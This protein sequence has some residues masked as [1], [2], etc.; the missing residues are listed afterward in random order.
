MSSKIHISWTDESTDETSFKIFRSPFAN[1]AN[2][3]EISS[4]VFDGSWTASNA[5]LLTQN[6]TPSS[7]GE[8]FKI[9]FN[10]VHGGTFYYGV[11]SLNADGSSSRIASNS[12]NL[13]GIPL[14]IENVVSSIIADVTESV[15]AS[16]ESVSVIIVDDQPSTTLPPITTPVPMPV[17]PSSVSIQKVNEMPTTL[18]PTTQAP[19]TQAPTTQA[20]T[21]Q[22]PT[23]QAPT[24]Q[25]PTT[26]APTTQAPTTTLAPTTQAP[27]T[28]SPSD[29]T[30]SKE[31]W[32]DS[33]DTSSIIE[34]SNI[35]SQWSDKSGNNNHAVQTNSSKQP[36]LTSTDGILFD[37]TDDSFEL[38]SGIESVPLSIYFLAKGD[39]HFFTH[40]GNAR[41]AV[42]RYSSGK[43][44][45]WNNSYG[46]SI[47]TSISYWHT[48]YQIF[49]MRSANGLCRLF[50]NG[51]QTNKGGVAWQNLQ[52]DAIGK[53]WTTGSSFQTPFVGYI[54]EIL[55][56][57]D[58]TR[59]EKIEGYLAHKHGISEYLPT[60]HPF[61]SSAPTE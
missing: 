7:T 20:P 57:P 16:P 50:I 34:S 54:K 37:G 25:A 48:R 51:S 8:T 42:N 53:A 30:L 6:S 61:K 14:P 43:A 44:F 3:T 58:M 29:S 60:S 9:E 39:G 4:V 2:A 10:E 1:L 47:N 27:T 56:T 32:L 36:T 38:T 28:W 59:R 33:T 13:I 19:T 23:T 18:A 12:I 52:I 26:Q 35:V 24:T 55:I 49:E 17:P 21:T 41:F 46:N 31:L 45:Y 15:P 11:S 40:G 22:A 5:N